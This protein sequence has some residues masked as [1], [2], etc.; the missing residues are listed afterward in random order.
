MIY[1]N[2]TVNIIVKQLS[3]G[4]YRLLNCR[5]FDSI[6]N[7]IQQE[8]TIYKLHLCNE[9]NK[10]SYEEESNSYH[11]IANIS[12]DRGKSNNQ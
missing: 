10:F 8:K 9:R 6:F 5:F 7:L 1:N 11:P 2:P 3:V 4:K 12:Y